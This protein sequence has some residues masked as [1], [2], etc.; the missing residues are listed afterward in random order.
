MKV[1]GNL[2]FGS[3]RVNDAFCDCGEDGKRSGFV[4]YSHFKNSA[5][6]AIKRD[7]KFP[8]RYVKKVPFLT[9]KYTKGVPF[10]PKMVYKRV[11]G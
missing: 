6:Q 1:L 2:S 5:F 10:L 7:A 11:R 8:A 3:K 4:V 9:E